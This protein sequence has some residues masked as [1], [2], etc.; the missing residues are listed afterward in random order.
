MRKPAPPTPRPS[1]SLNVH[2]QQLAYLREVDRHGSITRAAEALHV[3]QPALSQALAELERRLGT[4]LFE[5]AGR[6]R[7]LT[8]D[9]REVLAFAQGVLAQADELRARLLATREGEA[10]ALRVGMIDAASLYLLPDIVRRYRDQHPGVRLTL[11][12]AASETLLARLRSFE[13]DLAVVVAGDDAG[14]DTTQLQRE[15]LYLYAPPGDQRT[16]A[17]A[18]WVLY[19]PGSRTRAIIDEGFARLGIEPIVTLESGNPAVLRQM[20]SLGLGWAALPALVAERAAAGGLRRGPL[21]AERVIV[22]A[23]R[24]GTSDPRAA[25]FLR[26]ALDSERTSADRRSGS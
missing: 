10:G 25:A 26:L 19:P 5:R 4:A 23:Q 17:E 7:R 14:L 15:Q 1:G 8:A 12:V 2:F 6:G 18:E 20:V 9:G 22:A 21:L 24:R 3:S 13:L 16:P 11:A